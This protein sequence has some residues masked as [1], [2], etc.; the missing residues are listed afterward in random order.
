MAEP[1]PHTPDPELRRKLHRYGLILLVIAIVLAIWGEVSRVLAREAL[2]KDS[3]EATVLA[4]TTVMPTHN[5]NGEELIL[6]GSVQAF[7]EA[8]I[9]ARTS[10]YVKEWRSDIGTRVTRGQVLGEIETP[11]V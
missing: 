2:R 4:V 9:Y 3:A 8:P 5:E 6:P 11:E 10:G 1:S 7:I